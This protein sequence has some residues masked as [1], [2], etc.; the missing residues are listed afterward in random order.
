MEKAHGSYLVKL[1]SS[2]STKQSPCPHRV[3]RRQRIGGCRAPSLPLLGLGEI[4]L[5]AFFNLWSILGDETAGN[6]LR[7]ILDSNL[8]RF[9]GLLLGDSEA[10]VGLYSC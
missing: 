9:V 1:Q 5:R 8:G 3:S 7:A 4:Q 6:E 10:S 2:F